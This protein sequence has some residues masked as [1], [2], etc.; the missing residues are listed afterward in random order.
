MRT[1]DRE[2]DDIMRRAEETVPSAAE[3]HTAVMLGIILSLVYLRGRVADLSNSR[4]HPVIEVGRRSNY[5]YVSITMD[6]C[7]VKN[8]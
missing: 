7:Y 5:G 8:L 1:F 6:C 3:V 4:Y 2:L